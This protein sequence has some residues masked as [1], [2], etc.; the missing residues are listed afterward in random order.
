[1]QTQSHL[2]DLNT[3]LQQELHDA[4]DDIFMLQAEVANLRKANVQLREENEALLDQ[5]E[6]E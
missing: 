1:M 2:H 5:V 4:L 6:W 3:K